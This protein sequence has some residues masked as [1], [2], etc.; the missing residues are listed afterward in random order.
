MMRL[1]QNQDGLFFEHINITLA[2][3]VMSNTN[4]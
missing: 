2:S 3:S 4:I 1:S